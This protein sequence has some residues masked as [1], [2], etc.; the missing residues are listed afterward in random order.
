MFFAGHIG[1]LRLGTVAG[2]A[3]SAS[4][5]GTAGGETASATAAAYSACFSLLLYW[6]GPTRLS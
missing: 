5:A 3:G 2:G 6:L 4:A 1:E